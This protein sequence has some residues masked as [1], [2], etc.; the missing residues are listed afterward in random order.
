MTI[1]TQPIEVRGPADLVAK[2]PHLVGFHPHESLILVWLCSSFVLLTERVDLPDAATRRELLDHRR[3][4][5]PLPEPALRQADGVVVVL[6]SDD[7]DALG[8]TVALVDGVCGHLDRAGLRVFD[9]VHLRSGRWRSLTCLEPGCCPPDGTP[10]LAQERADA[11]AQFAFDG[12]A[13]LP[14]R[15][16]LVAQVAADDAA[17]DEVR[18]QLP[19]RPR[20]PRRGDRWRDAAIDDVVDAILRRTVPLDPE[21]RARVL[22]SL[23]DIRVRDTVLWELTQAA[24]GQVET[25]TVSLAA[26]TRSAPD[27]LCAP[28]A[29]CC[30]I[31]A[32]LSGDGALAGAAVERALTVEPGY[33][34]ARLVVTALEAGW[35]PQAWRSIIAEVDRATCRTGLAT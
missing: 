19:Q 32:W 35:P 22:H 3:E 26:L 21:R 6:S 10:V 23:A 15:A 12:R 13:V 9:V 28:A 4:W 8:E 16:A 14:D 33:G 20:Q 25:A 29:T 7:D 34:L 1:S 24:P 5:V 18:E 17:I 2:L 31:A 30:A 11:E 27:A